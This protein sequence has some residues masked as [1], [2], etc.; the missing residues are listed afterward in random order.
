VLTDLV[1]LLVI[2]RFGPA[3]GAVFFVVWM[4]GNAVDHATLSF[5][6]SVT[7]RLAHEPER[8]WELFRIGC[9][10]VAILFVPALVIGI[11]VA[12]PLLSIFGSD[13]AELGGNLLRL[14]LLGCI[15]RLLT[16]LVVALSMAHG[17]GVS[18]AV[19]EASSALGVVGFVALVPIGALSTIGFGFVVVQLV[20][21]VMACGVMFLQFRSAGGFTGRIE[22][23]A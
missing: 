4:A 1:P 18:V 5:A 9:R 13:Y 12:S 11:A 16:T 8:T 6:Q 20:V 21:A 14:V 23:R 15:P 17:R 19:L 10:K 2:A 7:V 22:A 3:A